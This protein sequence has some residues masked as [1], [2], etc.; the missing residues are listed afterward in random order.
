MAASRKGE[1][2]EAGKRKNDLRIEK[3]EVRKISYLSA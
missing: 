2:E 3:F 1:N